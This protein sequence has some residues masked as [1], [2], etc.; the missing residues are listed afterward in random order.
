MP[1]NN[2]NRAMTVL[3][4]EGAALAASGCKHA[5]NRDVG[6]RLMAQIGRPQRRRPSAIACATQDS[7]A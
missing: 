1:L 4:V 2:G 3:A 7:A 6:S 5:T